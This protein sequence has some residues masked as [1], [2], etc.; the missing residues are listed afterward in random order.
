MD[1]QS[2]RLGDH[3]RYPAKN[4]MTRLSNESFWEI[5]DASIKTHYNHPEFQSRQDAEL[6]ILLSKL[7][8]EQLLYFDGWSTLSTNRL[9]SSALICA[10]DVFYDEGEFSDDSL[11]Y[12]CNW[13]TSLGSKKWNLA[14]NDPDAFYAGFANEIDYPIR[15]QY[16]GGSFAYP[17]VSDLLELRGIDESPVAE[18]DDL[19]EQERKKPDDRNLTE[20]PMLRDRL[21]EYACSSFARYDSNLFERARNYWESQTGAGQQSVEPNRPKL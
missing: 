17:V 19:Y 8:D 5:V 20:F 18:I 16:D 15:C 6:R 13:V 12:H 9:N 14:Y 7:S 3:G 10:A 2:F 11:W 1:D 21:S 4:L